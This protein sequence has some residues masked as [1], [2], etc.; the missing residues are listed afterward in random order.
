MKKTVLG[1]SF[2]SFSRISFFL[3]IGI[4]VFSSCKKKDPKIE[5]VPNNNAPYYGKIP[6][7]KVENYV[8]RLFIDLVGR[9]AFDSEMAAEADNLI[10]NNLSMETRDALILK[11]QT[12]KTLR[13][14]DSTYQIA[15]HK[16]LYNLLTTRLCEGIGEADFLYYK[17]LTEFG[18]TI[19]STLGNWAGYYAGR[20]E[21]KRL[22]DAA[23]ARWLFMK[24]SIDISDYC[25]ILINNSVTFTK[26]DS[27][28]GNEDNTI[29]YTFNDLFHRPYTAYEFS[30]A[31]PMILE[32]KSGVLLGKSGHSKGDYFYILTHDKEFYE[33]TIIWLFKTFLARDPSVEEVMV[34]MQTFP[35][36]KDVIK[37]Q[38][39]ILKTDEYANFKFD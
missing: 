11:L 15:Y 24:D 16:Q 33:G 9:E 19:D 25:T 32:G 3:F 5:L 22:Y 37:I 34:N 18:V 30:Q 1:R 27:Y 31:R 7:V 10:A 8:N 2:S 21:A 13:P 6:R 23:E 38:R 17:G 35:T 12:D 29:K 39:R 20:L 26:T 36:D 28:M 14:G 4:L